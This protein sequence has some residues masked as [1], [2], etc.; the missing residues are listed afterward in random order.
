MLILA[1][2]GRMSSELLSL[3][4]SSFTSVT[5]DCLAYSNAGHYRRCLVALSGTDW[6]QGAM[7]EPG[8]AIH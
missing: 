1:P 6:I 5:A 2:Y 3:A 8:A 7:S 4:Y